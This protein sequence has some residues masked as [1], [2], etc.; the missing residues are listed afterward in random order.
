MLADWVVDAVGAD[1]EEDEP[2]LLL[3]AARPAVSAGVMSRASVRGF[4]VTA[5]GYPRP[6]AKIGPMCREW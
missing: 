3:Q 5:A 6:S 2:L 4:M 1:D